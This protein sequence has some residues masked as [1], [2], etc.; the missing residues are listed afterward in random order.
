VSRIYIKR[1]TAR[2]RRN[3]K[4]GSDCGAVSEKTFGLNANEATGQKVK[5][6][7]ARKSGETAVHRTG[8]RGGGGGVGASTSV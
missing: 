8:Q 6:P 2:L 7:A 5:M 1:E 3:K 4:Q